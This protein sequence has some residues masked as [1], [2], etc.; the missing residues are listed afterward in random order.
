M[1]VRGLDL[2]STSTGV[3]HPAGNTVTIAP[4]GDMMARC[5]RIRNAISEFAPVD[6]TVIEAIG[7]NQIQAAIAA[8]TVHALVLDDMPGEDVLMVTPS[9][10]KKWATGKGGGA[11]TDKVAIALKAQAAGW[12]PHPE[13]GDDEADAWWLWTIGMAVTGVWVVD[14]VKYRTD[15][16]ELLTG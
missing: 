7:T 1:T 6:L 11:G 9:Q 4:K 13:S 3:C 5:R 2:S 10:L 15:L 16:L 8:A 12:R 14:G